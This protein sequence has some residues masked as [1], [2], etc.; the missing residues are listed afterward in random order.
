MEDVTVSVE[1]I[2]QSQTISRTEAPDNTIKF[3][4]IENLCVKDENGKEVRF[5]DL[6][7]NHKTIIVFLRVCLS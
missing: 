7:K 3:W 1:E 4:K 6:Y 2:E 5:G